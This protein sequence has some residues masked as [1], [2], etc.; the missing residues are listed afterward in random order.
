MAVSTLVTTP[1]APNAN[2]YCDVA[3]ADQYQEDRPAVGTTWIA[4]STSAKQQGILWATKLMDALWCWT[5]FPTDSIQVLQWPRQGMLAATGWAYVDMHTIP[6][7]IQQATAEYA[8][9]L[10][11]SDLAGNSDIETLGITSLRAGPVAFTFKDGV[12][13]KPV[14]DIVVNLIPRSWGYTTSQKSGV[15]QMLR[16]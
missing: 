16:A 6:V 1:G 15:R 5:G 12:Y 11:A 7:E 4:A 3:F 10:L 2:A 8:R 14:P 13:A 9:Q